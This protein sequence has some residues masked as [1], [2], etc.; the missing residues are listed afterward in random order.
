M[1]GVAEIFYCR[2][3]ASEHALQFGGMAEIQKFMGESVTSDKKMPNGTVRKLCRQSN[4]HTMTEKMTDEMLSL[5]T[6]DNHSPDDKIQRGSAITAGGEMVNAGDW[7]EYGTTGENESC[8]VFKEGIIDLPNRGPTKMM[9]IIQKAT[10]CSTSC[11]SLG[12]PKLNLRNE[13]VAI[14]TSKVIKRLNVMHDCL[15]AKC[16]I[17]DTRVTERVEQEEVL[18]KKVHLHHNYDHAYFFK[19]FYML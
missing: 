1:N 13:V 3:N 7:V 14:H 10:E 8:G 5:L 17:R 2:K 19:N 16:S 15:G 18:T 9:A 12:C 6:S 4:R 11:D